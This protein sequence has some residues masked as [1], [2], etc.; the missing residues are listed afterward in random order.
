MRR[1]QVNSPRAPISYRASASSRIRRSA[2]GLL[3]GQGRQETVMRCGHEWCSR[4]YAGDRSLRC[5]SVA[6]WSA[7]NYSIVTAPPARIS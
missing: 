1:N 2:Q 7:P 3:S 5:V 4:R 6:P